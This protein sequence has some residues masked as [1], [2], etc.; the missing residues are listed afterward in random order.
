MGTPDT[1]RHCPLNTGKPTTKGRPAMHDDD[2][3]QGSDTCHEH[4]E[5]HRAQGV[6]SIDNGIAESLGLACEAGADDA[7]AQR[8]RE[9]KVDGQAIVVQ[10]KLHT[11]DVRTD[12]NG[13]A[14]FGHG[15]ARSGEPRRHHA[16]AGNAT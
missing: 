9:G 3:V 12:S 1:L 13:M 5:S 8:D 11:C 14:C 2:H 10:V 6:A 16:H 7:P 15:G 4:H